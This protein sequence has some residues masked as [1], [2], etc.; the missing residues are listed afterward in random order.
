[1]TIGRYAN[2]NKNEN[3]S[4]ESLTI[5]IADAG[6]DKPPNW[7]KVDVSPRLANSAKGVGLFR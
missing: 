2:L 5:G 6:R 1:V 4:N 7:K 3:S